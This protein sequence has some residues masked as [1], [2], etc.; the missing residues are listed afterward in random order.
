M[1]HRQNWLDTRAWLASLDRSPKT[2]Q[3]YRIYLR[4]L[5]EWADEIP[6]PNARNIDL[7]FPAYLVTARKDGKQVP[8]SYTSIYKALST[9]RM[10]FE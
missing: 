2:V 9:T 1:I 7:T 5:I 4:H 8:L 10:F 6:L 3:K